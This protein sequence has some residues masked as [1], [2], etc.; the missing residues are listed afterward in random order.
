MIASSLQ[1]IQES[2]KN[3]VVI[4][5]TQESLPFTAGE[6]ALYLVQKTIYTIN[7]NSEIPHTDVNRA[8]QLGFERLAVAGNRLNILQCPISNN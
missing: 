3:G 7:Q 4:A 8:R 6:L 2:I 5:T 1:S